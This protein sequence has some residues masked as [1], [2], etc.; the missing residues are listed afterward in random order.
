[1]IIYDYIEGVTII[2]IHNFTMPINKDICD[3]SRI[4]N[5][6]NLQFRY[7]I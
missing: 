5:Y 1:M 3:K 4:G 2:D 6:N 7:K